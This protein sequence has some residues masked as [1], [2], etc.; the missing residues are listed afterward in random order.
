MRVVMMMMNDETCGNSKW[1]FEENLGES[2][3]VFGSF[4]VIVGVSLLLNVTLV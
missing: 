2:E 3:M 4:G 1:L